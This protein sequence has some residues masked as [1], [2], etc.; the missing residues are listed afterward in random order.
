RGRGQV[1]NMTIPDYFGGF[2]VDKPGDWRI[3]V[4]TDIAPL[5]HFEGN[6]GLSV[7][8]STG[9]PGHDCNSGADAPAAGLFLTLPVTCQGDFLPAFTDI[10]D[11]YLFLLAA[12]QTVNIS[13][14]PNPSSDFN[15]ALKD[16]NGVQRAQSV[17]GGVGGT[18]RISF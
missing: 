9:A 5:P 8:H 17:D 1:G 18:E 3:R 13:M 14:T 11:T 7:S 4:A 10:D 12:G 2:M 16:P 15:I 6:Y